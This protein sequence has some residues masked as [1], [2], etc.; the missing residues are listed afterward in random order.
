M[1][2]R[3][4]TQAKAARFLLGGQ[5]RIREM[6]AGRITATVAGDTG[7]YRLGFHPR[8]RGGWYCTCPSRVPCSH[9]AALQSVTAQRAT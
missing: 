4:T 9:L 3:E 5:L 2:V 7:T 6:H 1:P 8:V